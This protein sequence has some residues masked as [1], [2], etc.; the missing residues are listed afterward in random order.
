MLF[1]S[2]RGRTSIPADVRAWIRQ[3]A[4]ELT[5]DDVRFIAIWTVSSG[6][7]SGQYFLIPGGF[8]LDWAA[9]DADAM[10][11]ANPDISEGAALSP[12]L[13][14]AASSWRAVAEFND[15]ETF[16][17]AAAE[18]I[19]GRLGFDTMQQFSRN[20]YGGVHDGSVRTQ[21]WAKWSQGLFISGK[22]IKATIGEEPFNAA[23]L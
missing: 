21:G 2:I 23:V 13:A 10:G 18:I 6:N 8:D 19:G 3:A 11:H 1:R 12:E 9:I 5:L 14:S 20:P 17:A 7:P 4:V 22:P 15:D 16:T